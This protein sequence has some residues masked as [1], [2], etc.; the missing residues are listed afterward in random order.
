MTSHDFGISNSEDNVGDGLE[1]RKTGHK[2]D[3]AW[4]TL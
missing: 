2:K 3:L 1:L 4:D